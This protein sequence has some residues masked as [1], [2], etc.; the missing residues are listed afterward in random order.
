[1]VFCVNPLIALLKP[2]ELTVFGKKLFASVG[3]GEVLQQTPHDD[4]GS[5]PLEVTEPPLFAEEVVIED[6]IVV[7]TVGRLNVVKLYVIPYAV[8]ASFVAYARTK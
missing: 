1:M 4:I 3:L 7:V 6:I 8:P 5:P 2:T